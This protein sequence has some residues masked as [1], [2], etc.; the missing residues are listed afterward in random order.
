MTHE[1]T[2]IL[3]RLFHDPTRL[4]I[5][6]TLLESPD[7]GS[8][9]G[10]KNACGLT[11]GNLQSHLRALEAAGVVTLTKEIFNDRAR[12]RVEITEAGRIRFLEYLEALETALRRAATAAGVAKSSRSSILSPDGLRVARGEA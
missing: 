11:D 7:E 6:S 12:T 3:E 5:L 9:T 10:L 4:A 1:S 2:E 8:F